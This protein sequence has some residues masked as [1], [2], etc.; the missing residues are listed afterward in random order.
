MY[1]VSYSLFLLINEKYTYCPSLQFNVY[2]QNVLVSD[3]YLQS[4]E[5]SATTYVYF[6]CYI[7]AI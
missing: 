2:E 6:V 5:I 4:N 7:C 3:Y 1:L